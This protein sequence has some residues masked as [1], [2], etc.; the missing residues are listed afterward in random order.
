LL[1]KM[2]GTSE[3]QPI[4]SMLD[5]LGSIEDPRI[6][7]KKLYPLEEILF[8]IVCAVM[9]GLQEWDEIVDFGELKQEWLRKYR[10]FLNGIP[11]HDTLNRVMGLIRYEEFEAFFVVWATG[12]A[13]SLVGKL[14]N[15]D[16]KKLRGSV[17]KREQQLPQKDGGKSA[18]HL[19]EAWCS[20]LNVCLGQ[21]K[22][23]DK[24]NEITAIPALLD[25]L[26]LGQSIVSID[27]MGCQKTIAAKI[28]GKEADYILALKAN[29]ETL[30]KNATQLFG[31]QGVGEKSLQQNTGHGRIETRT[32]RVIS[33]E[34]LPNAAD[35]AGLKNLIEIQS[36]RTE[37]AT[38]KTAIE[39]RYYLTSLDATPERLNQLVRE[40]WGIENKL[41]WAM[42]VQFGEDLST[43]QRKNVPQNFALIRRCA[44]NL[45]KAFPE[46]ISINRKISKCAISDEYRQKILDF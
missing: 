5:M 13:G 28:V 32:C 22:T 23:E 12:F 8:L 4:Y 40:H 46:K 24:S 7:R 16:G 19:V 39:F 35:W 26:E 36:E 2:Q 21:V 9:S 31:N 11:S 20:E 14:I 43:K 45:L 15:I 27:A 25:M 42:D 6:D 44:L 18:V 33:A 3:G 37:V 38:E 41:H 34:F 17:N 29:H 1:Q 30:Y 10:P